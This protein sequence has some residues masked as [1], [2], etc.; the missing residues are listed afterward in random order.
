VIKSQLVLKDKL[1]NR[2]CSSICK[3]Q[4]RIVDYSQRSSDEFSLLEIKPSDFSIS[5]S[6]WCALNNSV[7]ELAFQLT[8][9]RSF[10]V[11]PDYFST[12]NFSIRAE[13]PFDD[14]SVFSNFNTMNVSVRL[15]RS[16]WVLESD[17][18]LF[19][20]CIP[21]LAGAFANLTADPPVCSACPVGKY[22]SA[23]S[24]FCGLCSKGRFSS[25]PGQADE[26]LM[27]SSGTFASEEGSLFC[28]DCDIGFYS[29]EAR[30]K[31]TVH[32]LRAPMEAK[33]FLAR[34]AQIF[35]E[36]HVL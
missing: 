32:V 34:L 27:C 1:S 20:R 23:Q 18:N 22:S 12:Y 30:Q 29:Y 13:I 28:E 31:E 5:D 7:V 8:F 11:F 26:C 10:V 25:D 4:L 36:F 17:V 6:K 16:G 9:H 2:F 15:C 35:V 3:V 24:T 14:S 21:C 19:Y 33:L